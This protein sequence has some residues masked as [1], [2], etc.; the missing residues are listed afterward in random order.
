MTPGVQIDH[1]RSFPPSPLTHFKARTSLQPLPPLVSLH[2]QLAL[3]L[4]AD[5]A[6]PDPVFL[7]TTREIRLSAISA[8]SRKT[9]AESTERLHPFADVILCVTTGCTT[10][11]SPFGDS[12]LSDK[13]TRQVTLRNRSLPSS[14]ASRQIPSQIH[15][16][17]TCR[18]TF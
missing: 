2:F 10:F 13:R 18:E 3:L 6:S 9:Y 16:P 11:W 14:I 5:S 17:Q 8:T 1:Q 12:Q 7:L 15:P 4:C